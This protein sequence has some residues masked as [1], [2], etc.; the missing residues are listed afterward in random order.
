MAAEIAVVVGAGPGLGWALSK[1]FGQAGMIVAAAARNPRNLEAL[2]GRD[3]A[4]NVHLYPCD[5]AQADRVAELFR[6]IERDLGSPSLVVFNAG[7]YEPGRILDIRPEDFERCWRIGCLGGFLVGQAAARLMAPKQAGTIIFTGATASLRGGAGFANLAVPKFGLRALA[8]SMARE[9]G[10]AGIHVAHVVIDGQIDGERYRHLAAQR[11][12]DSLLSPD[13]I[14]DAYYQL[15]R[16]HR[17]AWTHELDMR[18]W[19]EKF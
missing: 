6:T 4:E 17:S 9:L 7:A 14:A 16:Q 12:P 11:G 18:P 5:A 3:K 10:P 1:R 15:H 2:A 19:S 13:A 8:Q